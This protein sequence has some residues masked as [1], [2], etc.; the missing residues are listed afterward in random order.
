MTYNFSPEK[1]ILDRDEA[2]MYK[3]MGYPIY[4]IDFPYG[5]R[6]VMAWSILHNN[7]ES[8]IGLYPTVLIDLF[9]KRAEMKKILAKYKSITE[10]MDVVYAQSNNTNL[11]ETIWGIKIN[12]INELKYLSSVKDDDIIVS[13]GGTLEEEKEDNKRKIK[14]IK[15]K[16]SILENLLY[17]DEDLDILTTPVFVEKCRQYYD[18]ASFECICAN[19]K[20][21]AIKIYMNT[22]YGEAGNSLSPFFLLELAG[23][24]T[25]SGKYNIK[26]VAKFVQGKGF[27][28]KY[29]DTDSL[30][31]VPPSIYFSEC[32][33]QFIEG[34]LTRE[35]YWTAMVRI[36]MR[37][38]NSLTIDINNYLYNTNGSKYLKMAYEEVLFPVVFTGKKKYYG[39]AHENEIN[40]KPKKLFIRGIDIIK[41]GQ[42]GL[43]KTIGERIMWESMSVNNTKTL[44][45]IVEDVIKDAIVNKDQWEFDNFIKSDAWRPNKQNIAVHIFMRRMK[46]HFDIENKE[47]QRRLGMG[48]NTIQPLYELP[49]AGERFNYVIVKRD[50]ISDM[51]DIHGRKIAIKKGDRMEC[52][53]VAR[54]KNLIIDITFYMI[55]Y[56]V[57]ICARF[58]N[59]DDEFQL[60][61]EEDD[62]KI[63]EY[64]QKMAKKYLENFIKRLENIDSNIL[65]QQ[66]N[67]YK[68][69]FHSVV[70]KSKEGLSP[71]IAGLFHGKI[72]NYETFI[73][74]IDT[75]YDTVNNNIIQ[76]IEKHHPIKVTRFCTLFMKRLNIY[77]NDNQISSTALYK[78]HSIII[79]LFNKDN[80]RSQ[81]KIQNDIFNSII[82]NL[83]IIALKYENVI[84][85]KINKERKFL[86]NEEIDEEEDS[87]HFMDLI[88]DDEKETIKKFTKYLLKIFSVHIYKFKKT[89]IIKHINQLKA[90]RLNI[91]IQPSTIDQKN[92]IKDSANKFYPIC[93]NVNL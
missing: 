55:N 1:I 40:F 60:K 17:L 66:G 8:K 44:R 89:M 83:N 5:E 12:S 71:L 68:K 50:L 24:V 43:A 92:A 28:I 9:N 2:M 26:L 73:N 29:G 34:K 77:N 84:I 31:L 32:D 64:S 65:R 48:M 87:I 86:L 20:Q 52:V 70:K 36:T 85:E 76:Y 11:K 74:N 61:D 80:K 57:G 56:G 14:I 10:V 51:F 45:M 6:R 67:I 27:H 93:G 47:N 46:I 4:E 7:D 69:A 82:D 75:L 23:G 3:E 30:Y 38:M 54:G 13:V 72:I 39:I 88:N 16:I 15:E 63:D 33:M 18:G 62:K 59:Y 78:W 25:S 81:Y 21:N 58:I 42:S 19:V 90:E 22:F 49:E 53:T 41:Q 79:N 35:E 91:T 37:V